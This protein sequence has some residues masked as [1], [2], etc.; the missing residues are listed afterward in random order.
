MSS[1]SHHR[2]IWDRGDAD[3]RRRCCA[4]TIGDD[5]LQDRRLVA[6]DIRGLAARTPP[7]SRA[8]GLLAPRTRGHPRRARGAR[9]AAHRARRMDRGAERRGRPLGRRAPPDRAHRRR[10][11][12][13]CTPAAAATSRSPSTCACGC[14]RRSTGPRSA[15]DELARACRAVG[16]AHG[17]AC[18]CPGYTHLRR[19]MPSSVADWIAAHARAFELDR[20]ALLARAARAWPSARW[21]RAPATAC[22]STW[23][24]R[25]V[26][27]APRLRAARGARDAR[28]ARA[29]ARRARLRSR[30]SRGSRSTSASSR[31]TSGS[32]RPT[33]SASLRLPAGLTTGSSL[34]PQKRNPDVIELTRAHC[35]AARRRPR[36]AARGRCATCPRATTATSSC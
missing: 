20:E 35:R 18:R 36:R 16:V 5:W 8:P 26:A 2:P 34:M 14:A 24:A 9:C 29:R 19:A 23:R 25:H 27:R 6:H 10:P 28:A 3:R 7:G 31:P 12:S 1:A 11:A 4:F 33:S 32:S 30:R 13:A 17:V 15:L 21:A 22:R